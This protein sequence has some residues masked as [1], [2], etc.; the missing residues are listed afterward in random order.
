MKDILK[1]VLIVAAIFGL[2]YLF[3][4]LG[5]KEP[6]CPVCGRKGPLVECQVCNAEVCKSCADTDHYLENLYESGEM[7]E[8]LEDHDYYVYREYDDAINDLID[9]DPDAVFWALVSRGYLVENDE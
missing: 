3:G 6:E 1:V 8:Y 2:I 5:E 9:E 4:I 7:Q